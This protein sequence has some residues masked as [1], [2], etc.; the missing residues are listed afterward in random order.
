MYEAFFGL[1]E[2]PFDLTPNPRFLLLT[3]RHREALSN[4]QYGLMSRRGLTL[5]VGEA[6]TGKT[7]LIRT[8]VRDFE[9]Q[10]AIVAYLNNPTLTRAEFYEFV[11]E[12]YGLG[13]EAGV[14]KFRLLRELSQRLEERHA[15]GALTALIIDEAQALP[16]ELLEEVRLLANTETASDKLLPIVLAGQPELA[17]RLNDPSLRQLK[18]RVAL[19]CQLGALTASETADYIAGR[20]RVAGGNSVQVFTRQAVDSIHARSGGI[21]R[22]ISV[23]CDNSLISG[24]AADR[25]PVS[26]DIVEDVCRDFDLGSGEPAQFRQEAGAGTLQPDVP[27]RAAAPAAV[28]APGSAAAPAG[29]PTPQGRKLFEHFTTR[30]RFSFF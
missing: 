18:Q 11:A 24:F 17:D 26:R 25:R 15:Q 27:L 28:A 14:S 4:L 5:L 12:A 22:L 2:R 1:R 13:A 23:I 20:I 6:G 21:P 9:S 3:G 19:R 10:G 16:D 7:T 8:V 29:P 30:R